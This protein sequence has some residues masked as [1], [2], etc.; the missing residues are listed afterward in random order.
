GGGGG[1]ADGGE[2]AV[3]LGL[4]AGGYL[5]SLATLEPRKG[6]DV[7]LAALARPEAPDLPLVVVGQ[8]G[9]GGVDPLAEA[10]RL[11][12]PAGRV[13]VLG[14]SPGAD[15]AGGRSRA[16]ALAAPRRGAGV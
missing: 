14:R 11:G 3:R 16:P 2:R 7:L 15:L 5:L 8:P 9:W 12:V 13:R 4:P 1:A 6:L 10:A